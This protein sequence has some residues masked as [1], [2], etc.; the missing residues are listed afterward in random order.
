VEKIQFNDDW[1]VSRLGTDE[2][3]TRVVL[4]HDAMLS[5]ARSEQSPGGANIGWFAGRDYL[6]SKDFRVPSGYAGKTV[7]FEF[8]GVYRNAEVRLNGE[9]IASHAYGYTGFLVE[10]AERL[11]FGEVNRIE[12]IARNADQPNS[13]WYSG[14]GIYRPV[15][16]WVGDPLHIV[17]G[18][19]RVR[20]LST[21]PARI[22]VR[23]S[24]TGPGSVRVDILDGSEAVA[25]GESRTDG[26][27]SLTIDV[28]GA[29]A[30]S[31]RS[32]KLYTGRVR[33][34]TDTDEVRFGLRKIAYGPHGLQINGDRVLLRGACVHHD[35]GLLGAAAYPEAEA[36][37]VKILKDAGFNAIRSS[38][39]P[40]SRSFL[41]ACDELGMLVVD[42]YA[43]MWYIHKTLHDH[44][45]HFAE[46]WRS[47]LA[48]MVRKDYNHPSVIMYSIGNEVAE[49]AQKRGI[50]LTREMADFLRALDDRPVTCAVNV[51]FNFL[52]SAGLG[53][54][55]DKKA[56]AE[57]R[58]GRKKA[59]GS[60]FFNN[61]AGLVG[62]ETMKWGA[63][64]PPCDWK[65]RAAFAE[66]DVAG[67]NYGIR[68]YPRDLRKYPTRLVL[69]TETFTKDAHKFWEL[70]K[71]NPRLVGDFVWA[72]FDYLG[73]V[74]LGAW[75]YSDYA[76]TFQHTVGWISAGCG[77]IDLTGKPQAE[78]SYLRVVYEE[79]PG[80]VIAVTPVNHTRDRHSPAAWRMS[81]ALESWAWNGCAGSPARIEVYARAAFVELF[82]NGVS[83]G[84]R[85]VGRNCI[86]R[87][88]TEYAPGTITAVSLDS[89]GEAIGR[90]SLR[91][92]GDHTD[93][94]VLPESLTVAAGGLCFV[95]L[96]YTDDKGVW[97]PLE[98][99]EVTLS[100]RGGRLIALGNASPFNAGGYLSPSTDTYFGEALAVVEAGPNGTVIVSADDG[101]RVGEAQIE[102][103]GAGTD[104]AGA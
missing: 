49:T 7:L 81:N 36:R 61:L 54:Y 63:A 11:R 35:N 42:E 33:F 59:V 90:R 85:R 26:E 45:D 30:W 80:P 38:H 68:R 6:Y 23:V 97:K 12:V 79:E 72:G 62:D 65:T 71:A 50:A 75:E 22:E 98:R 34:E 18:G 1:H 74:G 64:L 55:S 84:K 31:P 48:E 77:R 96:R 13:R 100:V 10:A 69:G 14:A 51:F 78:M 20:T 67:Y 93:L 60:E 83:V 9:S 88:R 19:I 86:A 29:V 66:L 56:A 52:S 39:N 47:D 15:H 103:N 21:D 89:A 73:E 53:V 17:P 43:D 24:T 40:C 37:K 104:G 5:E 101:A 41:D 8:E 28:P 46:E 57:A 44:A 2:P 3:P 92:A 91:S 94:R 99:H 102:V 25:W 87:F 58:G 70:A 16:M 27:L 32:P 4:P 76:P 95:R 82:V